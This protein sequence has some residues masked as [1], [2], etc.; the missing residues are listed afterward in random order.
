MTDYSSNRPIRL[1]GLAIALIA[2]L[3][4]ATSSLQAQA[5]FAGR[6]FT[7]YSP[8]QGY[9]WAVGGDFGV[10]FPFLFDTPMAIGGF[11]NYN[12]GNEFTDEDLGQEV[13]Q[14]IAFYGGHASSLWVDKGVF[15]RGNGQAGAAVL[16]RQVEGEASETQTRFFLGGG[17][18]VGKRLGDF[19]IGAEPWFPIVIGS[20]YVKAAVAVYVS[21]VYQPP[22]IR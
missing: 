13:E 10:Q 7:G 15:L 4:T 12:F 17:V 21:V 9:G 19:V 8:A 5:T 6:A 1:V 16:R 14:R 3:L 20:D 2:L 11:V 22:L 18:M